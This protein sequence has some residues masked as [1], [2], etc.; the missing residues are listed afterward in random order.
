MKMVRAV[1][2]V[3]VAL[4]WLEAPAG[5]QCGVNMTCDTPAGSGPTN[6]AEP[7]S[8]AQAGG[9]PSFGLCGTNMNCPADAPSA[10]W[11]APD[12][13]GAPAPAAE[14]VAPGT[15]VCG[16]NMT[17]EP[18]DRPSTSTPNSFDPLSGLALPPG[19]GVCGIN[20]SCEPSDRRTGSKPDPQ[21]TDS[22]AGAPSPRADTPRSDDPPIFGKTPWG[23]E[24]LT[25]TIFREI[26]DDI[27]APCKREPCL[28]WSQR[29]QQRQQQR[30]AERLRP[31]PS[32][33]HGRR[34]PG[35]PS[36][37]QQRGEPPRR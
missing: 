37:G 6:V 30:A 18:S 12:F 3:G 8:A 34:Q 1:G 20:M 9:R 32:R 4:L 23:S 24:T 7:V 15:G 31:F 11:T 25:G 33:K 10:P 36:S 26:H 16:V 27:T 29:Q 14:S 5:A 28:A 19:V 35:P 2:F 17:C 13:F 22:A 21:P